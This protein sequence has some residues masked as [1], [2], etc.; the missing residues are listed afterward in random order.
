[1]IQM[2]WET[3]AKTIKTGEQKSSS[4][5]NTKPKEKPI[6]P[7]D[8][9]EIKNWIYSKNTM[10]KRLIAMIYGKD[11]TGKSG[12]VLDYIA[13]KIKNTDKKAI[14]IDLDS[15]CQPL[16]M[17]YHQDMTN[18]IFVKNPLT[19]EVTDQG[20]E[21]DYKA[22][23]NKIKATLNYVQK[24]WKQDNIEYFVFDGLSTLLKHAE[25]QMRLDRHI[26]P[27]GGVQTRYWLVRN[28]LFEEVLE[29][30]KAIGI[31]A[32]LIAHEDFI[33]KEGD[34][35]AAIKQK[36]NALVHQK[37]KTIRE[38]T[39]TETVFKAV[40]D[41]SKYNILKEGKE[42]IFGRVNLNE[43]KMEWNVKEI[44]EGL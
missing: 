20:V 41:K 43:K 3:V 31:N 28:K 15:G 35:L 40:I 9:N 24:N 42:Y 14:V 21:I 18:Q 16:M 37:I 44:F 27:D 5:N 11:G 4:V 29:Q 6:N 36:T 25:R 33:P 32:F 13:S 12:I 23:I 34:E 22:T 8:E 30:V 26:A 38:Q 10:Q 39:K 1:M 7:F 2:G 19:I 17:E